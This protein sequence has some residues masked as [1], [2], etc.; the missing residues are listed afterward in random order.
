MFLAGVSQSSFKDKSPE[1]RFH[2]ITFLSYSYFEE[3]EFLCQFSKKQNMIKEK[4]QLKEKFVDKAQQCFAFLHI[5]PTFKF[6]LE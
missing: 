6:A 4:Y 3:F 2:R 1:I 5:K